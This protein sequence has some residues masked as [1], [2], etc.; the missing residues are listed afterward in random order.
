LQKSAA[1]T[2]KEN[3]LNFIPFCL[4]FD[5]RYN[6]VLSTFETSLNFILAIYDTSKRICRAKRHFGFSA[7][8]F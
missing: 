5:I 4:N 1:L 3:C 8:E 7:L 6:S 2:G